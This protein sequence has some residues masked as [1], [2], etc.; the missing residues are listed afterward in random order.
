MTLV[1]EEGA[2]PSPSPTCMHTGHDCTF[3]YIL[4]AEQMLCAGTHMRMQLIS[5]C[6]KDR[7]S[8]IAVLQIWHNY[9]TLVA[10]DALARTVSPCSA[11]SVHQKPCWYAR[12]LWRAT[13]EGTH[14]DTR[15]AESKK[16]DMCQ[17]R[18]CQGAN[19]PQQHSCQQDFS[20]PN[21]AHTCV[22]S[23]CHSA[24]S[25]GWVLSF[26]LDM[27]WQSSSTSLKKCYVASQVDASR[28]RSQ[29]G[30]GFVY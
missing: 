18:C 24:I 20:T 3:A 16:A 22:G 15:R 14:K 27:S 29:T 13:G 4:Q 7:W 30:A 11:L 2:N 26:A 25:Q 17:R 10:G 23:C 6:T 1:A 12:L 9:N 28:C 21:P 19:R 8:P 5:K